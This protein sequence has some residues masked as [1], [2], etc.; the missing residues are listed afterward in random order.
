MESEFFNVEL[1]S[2]K[3]FNNQVITCKI[4]AKKKIYENPDNVKFLEDYFTSS[5]YLRKKNELIIEEAFN[6]L[7][8]LLP[9]LAGKKVKLPILK[10]DDVN[11]NVASL[12][13]SFNS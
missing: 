11:E 4:F 6:S 1:N 13:H 7:R 3:L 12:P 8:S 10:K 9:S 2:Q 5:L